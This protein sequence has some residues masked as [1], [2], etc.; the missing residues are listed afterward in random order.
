VHP[1]L[2]GAM[3]APPVHTDRPTGRLAKAKIT[4]QLVGPRGGWDWLPV[5]AFLVEHPSAGAVLI[6]TGLH[7]SCSG[8]A[9]ANMGAI[10]GLIYEIRTDHDQALRFQLPA[11]GVQPSE[12]AVVVMTHL[13]IDHAS[14]VS[15][16]PQATFVIDGREW[17][18]AAAGGV[19][20][21]YHAR[22]FDHAFEWRTVDFEAEEVESFSGFAHSVD[23]FGDGSV[24]LVSTPGHTAGHLSVVLRTAHREVLVVADAAYTERELHGEA[25]PLI[26]HD[27]HLHR[28][29]LK[30]INRYVEQTPDALAIPSHDVEMWKRL[31]PVYG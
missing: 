17:K 21:G 3:H 26:C 14:A 8:G 23:L 25:E 11:R 30:E 6:D 18:A 15:E 27:R 29:S 19:R 24:R 2:T 28:R 22:Q 9:R 12:V 7:P 20:G 16:F 13:H 31:E 4:R 5:P 10:A 1:I